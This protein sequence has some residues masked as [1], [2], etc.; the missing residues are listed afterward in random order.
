MH[1]TCLWGGNLWHIYEHHSTD[2]GPWQEASLGTGRHSPS[3]A[4]AIPAVGASRIVKTRG[5]GTDAGQDWI[6]SNF[7]VYTLNVHIHTYIHACMH[8][9]M[10]TYIRTYIHTYIHTYRHTHTHTYIHTYIHIYIYIHTYNYIYMIYTNHLNHDWYSSVIKHGNQISPSY[11]SVIFPARNFHFVWGFPSQ[12]CLILQTDIVWSICRVYRWS[13][14]ILYI[15]YKDQ[16]YRYP[17]D[18]C[19]GIFSQSS[20][21]KIAPVIFPWS[22][23][24]H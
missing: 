6:G 13:R 10:H 22:P 24:I 21:Q 15:W 23:W 19:S 14:Y 1:A 2:S 18:D 20:P 17:M 3:S 4:G 8:A 11:S 9:C 5:L 16:I 7:T 12:P